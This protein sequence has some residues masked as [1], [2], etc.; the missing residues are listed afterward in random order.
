MLESLQVH[1]RLFTRSQESNEQEDR[2]FM[3]QRG[4]LATHSEEQQ[5]GH[6]SL[7]LLN[8]KRAT[9]LRA[10]LSSFVVSMMLHSLATDAEGLDYS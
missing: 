1:A 3:L 8:L 9:F 4:G 2:R 10:L 5:A 7:N 6:L